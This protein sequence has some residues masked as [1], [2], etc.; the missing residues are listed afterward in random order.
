MIF[1]LAADQKPTL[2]LNVCNDVIVEFRKSGT[3][4]HAA[5]LLTYTVFGNYV[6]TKQMSNI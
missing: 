5:G 4:N 3:C 2:C 1:F 6:Q